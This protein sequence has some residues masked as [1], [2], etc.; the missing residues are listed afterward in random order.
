M[1]V[2]VRGF[3][4]WGMPPMVRNA[5]VG[6]YFEQESQVGDPIHFSGV[7]N[8]SPLMAVLPIDIGTIVDKQP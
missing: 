5:V 1:M 2:L 8:R 3:Y 7:A 6:A 4:V